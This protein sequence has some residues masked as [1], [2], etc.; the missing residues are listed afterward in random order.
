MLLASNLSRNIENLTLLSNIDIS[1]EPGS[2]TVV[3]GPSG[4]GK[5]TLLR[6]LS[7]LDLPSSGTIRIDDVVYSFPQDLEE[8]IIP[9]WPTVTVVFQQLFLWPHL[10]LRQNLTLPLK[11]KKFRHSHRGNGRNKVKEIIDKLDMGAFIDRYPNEVSIGQRQRAAIARALVL[12]PRY[13]LLDEITS[14]L[15]V[16]Q[17]ATVL[18]H[19][20]LLREQGIGILLVTHLLGFAQRAADR[21]LFIDKGKAIESGGPEILKKPQSTRLQQ[22]V[23]TIYQA[24]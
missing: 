22:F 7:L 18:T 11:E 5:T 4:S 6:A 15:D 16:E 1:V 14:A 9:P 13:I 8:E 2:I 23:A 3:I 19:L 10:T 12:Q 21:I 17:I 20:Q 24:T